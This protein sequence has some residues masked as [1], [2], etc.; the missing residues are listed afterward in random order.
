ME[1]AVVEGAVSRWKLFGLRLILALVAYILATKLINPGFVEWGVPEHSDDWLYFVHSRHGFVFGDLLRPR[2]IMMGLIKSLGFVESPRV[3]VTLLL[4]PA[5]LLPVLI[6]GAAELALNA[7]FGLI[8]D[9]VYF[10]LCFSL[11]TFY[12]LSVYDFGA[13]LAGIFAC[14]YVFFLEKYSANGHS[15]TARLVALSLP[16]IFVWL[17]VESK[18][19]YGVVLIALPYLFVKKSG[20]RDAS[21]QALLVGLVVA[22]VL[23]K[24]VALGSHFI[25]FHADKPSSYA[26]ANSSRA[27]FN[28]LA[29]YISW[30]L[31]AGAC[32]LMVAASVRLSINGGWRIVAGVLLLSGLAILPVLAIPR[33]LFAMYSWYASSIILLILPYSI[34]Y[35][36]MLERPRV[37]V[38]WLSV[39]LITLIAAVWSIQNGNKDFR[40]WY[41]SNQRANANTLRALA[42]LRGII[43]PGDRILIAGPL[44]AYNP[45]KNDEFI[46]SQLPYS[47]SWSV[48]VPVRDVGLIQQSSETK[49]LVP[50][51]QIVVENFDRVAYFDSFGRML[52]VGTIG[53][54]KKLDSSHRIAAMFCNSWTTIPNA[55]TIKCLYELDENEAIVSLA[56]F[57]PIPQASAW[58]W[59]AVGHA[60]ENLGHRTEA[61]VAY[62]EAVTMSS[63][64][65]FTEAAKRTEPSR[66]L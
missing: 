49:R 9:F 50:A 64:R 12:E 65:I 21:F 28:A 25:V 2:P 52:R 37:T 45:F 33:H 24:D 63:E 17:S 54:M 38:V 19:T 3:F 4:V 31:P 36:V 30:L 29:Y 46:S 43:K 7:R 66:K 35:G 6:V 60:Q 51:N 20:W 14:C 23:F 59:Y 48:A 34:H 27:V 53:E 5:I 57:G 22:V 47:F 42:A 13:V 56:A 10:F 39:L 61:H 32:L 15:K 58:T 44:N 26:I 18:P 1:N 8:T 16:L 11:A 62:A 40:G 41:S 55:Q